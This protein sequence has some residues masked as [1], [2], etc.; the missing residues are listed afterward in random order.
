MFAYEYGSFSPKMWRKKCQNT[1]PV[2]LRRKKEKEK[3]KVSMTNKPRCGGGA[4]GLS[5]LGPLK[6]NTF[7][8]ASLS[9]HFKFIM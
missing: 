5:A 6:K 4:K 3:K 7:F 2:I 1:F 9:N 8:A